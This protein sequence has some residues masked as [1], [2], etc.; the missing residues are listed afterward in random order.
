MTPSTLLQAQIEAERTYAGLF[1]CGVSQL[2]DF[3]VESLLIGGPDGRNRYGV[4]RL[5]RTSPCVSSFSLWQG[6]FDRVNAR[7]EPALLEIKHVQ[8]LPCVAG[9][10][11]ES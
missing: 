9:K 5:W 3:P 11:F 10:P 2:R 8:K 1:K 4:P 6:H 7:Q